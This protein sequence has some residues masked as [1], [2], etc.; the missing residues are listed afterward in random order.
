MRDMAILSC[1][2]GELRLPLVPELMDLAS[3]SCQPNAVVET[4]GEGKFAEG[5]GKQYLMQV[6]F[7]CVYRCWRLQLLS[8]YRRHSSFPTSVQLESM[9]HV[10]KAF[11]CVRVTCAASAKRR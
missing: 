11:T 8:P 3:H 7:W 5:A 4:L 2:A 9:W 6:Y 10:A 1:R